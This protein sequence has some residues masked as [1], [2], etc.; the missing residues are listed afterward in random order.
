MTEARHLPMEAELPVNLRAAEFSITLCD[1]IRGTSKYQGF[2]AEIGQ[3]CLMTMTRWNF[4]L[5]ASTRIQGAKEGYGDLIFVH[6]ANT[7]P[8]WVTQTYCEQPQHQGGS[9]KR[10]LGR[11]MRRQ[12]EGSTFGSDPSRPPFQPHSN[13]FSK[14]WSFQPM[15][16]TFSAF[17]IV[18]IPGDW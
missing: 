10:T 16:G 2:G 17:A 9:A 3:S 14:S 15:M 13:V 7:Y 18:M 11:Q 5:Q 12:L 1:R 4:S 8:P 6:S